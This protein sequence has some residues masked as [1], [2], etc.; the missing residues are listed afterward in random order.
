MIKVQT[1]HWSG[2]RT[3]TKQVTGT[4]HKRWNGAPVL[5]KNTATFIIT[6]WCSPNSPI[7]RFWGLHLNSRLMWCAYSN[8]TLEAF[9]IRAI[10][11]KRDHSFIRA[12]SKSVPLED[13]GLCVCTGWA[14]S[15]QVNR[16]LHLVF[17]VFTEVSEWKCRILCRDRHS[18]FCVHGKKS[19]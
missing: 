18:A 12:V 13:T 16:P 2:Q 10:K 9:T 14:A 4:P 7:D 11:P 5:P 15:P 3:W 1:A 17:Y 8:P 6:S 19:L